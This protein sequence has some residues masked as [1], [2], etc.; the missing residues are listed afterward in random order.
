M[1][2]F[3]RITSFW[4]RLGAE[5]LTYTKAGE[6]S[7]AGVSRGFDAKLKGPQIKLDSIGN[8]Q[9]TAKMLL[10]TDIF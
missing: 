5:G 1:L 3:V 4:R 8:R 7:M 10:K 2:C 6:V 9:L